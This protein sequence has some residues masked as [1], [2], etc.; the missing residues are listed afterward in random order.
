M[1]DA[2]NQDSIMKELLNQ[3]NPSIKPEKR[4]LSENNVEDNDED[5]QLDV[6]GDVETS[7]NSAKVSHI[8]K[9][10]QETKND[11]DFNQALEDDDISNV[12]SQ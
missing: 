1:N 5:Y 2:V 10:L 12:L 6:P 8:E 9:L 3:K 11:K 7:S 4:Q